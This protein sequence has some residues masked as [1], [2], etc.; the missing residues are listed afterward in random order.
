MNLRNFKDVRRRHRIEKTSNKLTQIL[1]DLSELPTEKYVGIA[2]KYSS[3]KPWE[4][5]A[6]A[7]MRQGATGQVAA[8]EILQ[9]ARNARWM[10]WATVIAAF[11]IP[12]NMAVAIVLD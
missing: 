2:L 10:R 6:L 5:A 7:L 4:L 3:L 1:A 12:V 8:I 9:S 11:S